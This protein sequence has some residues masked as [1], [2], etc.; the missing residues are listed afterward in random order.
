MFRGFPYTNFHQLNLDWLIETIKDVDS[1]MVKSVNNTTPDANGNINLPTVSAVSS[2]N[3][4]GADGN[5]NVNITYAN[6]DPHNVKYY[7]AIG[8]GVT[9]DTTAIQLALDSAYSLIYFPQGTY[10]A[11]DL[12]IPSNKMLCG[13]GELSIIE[14]L[15]SANNN[16]LRNN[17]VGGV[18][19]YTANENIEICNLAFRGLGGV[20]T[21]LAFGH[22][23]NVHIHNCKF[24]N[25]NTWHFIEFNGCQ[26]SSVKN[27]YFT[28]YLNG[29]SPTEMIQLDAMT[30]QPIFPWFGPYDN[31]ACRLIE[32]CNNIFNGN[33]DAT[34]TQRRYPAGIGNHTPLDTYN[35]NI[36]D[37]IFYNMFS[38]IC[39]QNLKNSNINGNIMQTVRNGVILY[40]TGTFVQITS[41]IISCDGVA[42]DIA[43]GINIEGTQSQIFINGNIINNA[44][45]NGALVNGSRN[46]IENNFIYSCLRNGLYIPA[47][48][49]FFNIRNNICQYSFSSTYSDFYIVLGQ[50]SSDRAG[51][52][53][54]INNQCNIMGVYLAS[55]NPTDQSTYFGNDVVGLKAALPSDTYLVKHSNFENFNY[56]A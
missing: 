8:D 54:I 24:S 50:E 53:R 3:G 32:I 30:S 20:H 55:N 47:D 27:C 42:D 31:T 19:G 29:G 41:N 52:H 40:G 28:D 14:L 10:K 37:N 46:V 43:N 6:S 7:G 39:F 36:H 9:D 45:A 2:V 51:A 44:G 23:T 35:I 25:I 56:T 49:F 22:C 16:I 21:L 18:G 17:S 12:L 38:G 33:N 26:F 1:E 4:I 34:I 48:T 13:I 5:G 15:T 11:A